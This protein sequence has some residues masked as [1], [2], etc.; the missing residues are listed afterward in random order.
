[1]LRALQD[2]EHYQ[3]SKLHTIVF[4][5]TPSF[6]RWFNEDHEF[7][8]KAVHRLLAAQKHEPPDG[9]NR[10]T[11]QTISAIVDRLP[12]NT[13]LTS[14]ISEANVGFE[15]L[16]VLLS[17]RAI[18]AQEVEP[19]TTGDAP[20][21]AYVRFI[22]EGKPGE[23]LERRLAGLPVANTLFRNGSISTVFRDVWEL[24]EKREVETRFYRS[25]RVPLKS[26]DVAIQTLTKV[27]FLGIPMFPL[28]RSQEIVSSMGNIIREVRQSDTG[29]G[30]PASTNLET[31][32]PKLL[33]SPWLTERARKTLSVFALTS[34]KGWYDNASLALFQGTYPPKRP[35][36]LRSLLRGD[37]RMHRVTGGGGG[38]GNKKGLL[39]LESGD[40]ILS[41]GHTKQQ[42]LPRAGEDYSFEDKSAL[43][44]PGDNVQFFAAFAGQQKAPADDPEIEAQSQSFLLDEAARVDASRSVHPRI[45]LGTNPPEEQ[46]PT[47]IPGTQPSDAK[48]IFVPNCFG[49]LSE[50]G[51]CLGHLEK[52]DVSGDDAVTF[53][54]RLDIPYT[55]IVTEGAPEGR[56]K[57]V[58]GLVEL[59]KE[60]KSASG[61]QHTAAR[62]SFRRAKLGKLPNE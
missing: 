50:G 12:S 27:P 21:K 30:V 13:K 11:I 57:P 8:S 61:A 9:H 19:N 33:Q 29:E 60:T 53:T 56:Y 31:A 20:S 15:G 16:S 52:S 24:R 32:V 36:L 4:L 38:W 62:S 23:T 26:F 6:T 55:T 59:K 25:S 41:N 44:S 48:L 5:A 2:L 47:I 35:W 17:G 14:R 40:D 7:L 10:K 51:A 45:I 46:Y 43:V 58:L 42:A 39:S 3:V 54:S 37:A 18:H 28:T 22:S 34:R 49:M 1:M